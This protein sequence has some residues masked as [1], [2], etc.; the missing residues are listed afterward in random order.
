MSVAS[1]PHFNRL[2]RLLSDTDLGRN[3]SPAKHEF[4]RGFS[5]LLPTNG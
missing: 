4:N 1:R 5:V 2:K 3:L